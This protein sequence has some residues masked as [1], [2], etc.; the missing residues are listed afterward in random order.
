MRNRTIIDGLRQY[1]WEVQECHVP[2]WERERDKTGQY[3]RYLSLCIR[4]FEVLIAYIRLIIKYIFSIRQYDVMIVG[5]IGHLD[6]PLAW[7]LTR[8]PRRPLVFSPLISLYDTLVDDRAAFSKTSV[9][10]RFLRWLDRWTCHV[11]DLVLLD[12]DA[13]IAYFVETFDL[14]RDKFVRVFVGAN[15]QVFTPRERTRSDDEFHVTFVGK[16][17]PLHGLQTMMR[18]AKCL[19]DEPGIVFNFVGAGQLSVDIQGLADELGLRN[20]RFPDWVEYEQVPDCLAQADVC[21]GIFGTTDK[22]GR[23]IPGKLY[24]AIS[25]GRPIITG[26]SEA[27]RELLTDGD[28]VILCRRGDPESL[29]QAILRARSDPA[30]L[31]R[32][33]EGGYRIYREHASEIHIGQTVATAIG[34]LV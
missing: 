31:K 21:L 7:L 11:A 34:H 13:H 8:I 10:S 9:M 19:N 30:L 33:A 22:A 4:G 2:I 14:P 29:S 15:E 32:I 16:F 28:S 25:M 5:Y 6:I 17:T 1:G 20:V 24:E 23:V 26:E 27:I 12:T 3:L 18:A